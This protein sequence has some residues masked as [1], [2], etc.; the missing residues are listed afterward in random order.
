ML[1]F[2]FFKNTSSSLFAAVALLLIFT[3]CQKD[4]LTT[5][6][7]V[8]TAPNNNL[9]ADERSANGTIVDIAVGNPAFSSLVAAVLKTNSAGLLSRANLNATVFAPTNDAFAQLPAPFNNADNIGAITD[10]GQIQLLGQILKYHVVSGKRN[11]AQLPNGSY[12]TLRT[13]IT[14]QNHLLFISRNATGAVLVNGNAQV[15]TADVQATNGVIHIVNRVLMPPTQAIAQIAI[16]NG[17]FN[18]LVAALNKTGLANTFFEPGNNLTV[19][20]PTD[21]AF[22]KLPAPLNNAANIK[23]IQDAATINT[24]RN[25][26]LYHVVAG[27]VFSADLREG[28]QPGTLLSGNTVT[29]TLANGPKVKGAGNQTAAN[30]AITDILAINGVIHAIDQVLLP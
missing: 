26:L 2:Y 15:V 27:H 20:A 18:A 19:F 1:K 14:A 29:I 23:G 10:A 5:D 16:A 6:V 4:A 25:V 13:A 11:A 7:S 9:Q 17:N 21:A 24:L 12:G 28:I 3:D 30:I 8:L 22:A